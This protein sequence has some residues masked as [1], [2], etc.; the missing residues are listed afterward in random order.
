MKPLEIQ[1]KL[2]LFFGFTSGIIPLYAVVYNQ[3]KKRAIKK[4]LARGDTIQAFAI[5]MSGPLSWGEVRT[6]TERGKVLFK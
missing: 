2:V 5:W 4:A 3:W 1:S 6:P